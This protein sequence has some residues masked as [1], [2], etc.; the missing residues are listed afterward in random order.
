MDTNDDD[1]APA[2]EREP[3]ILDAMQTLHDIE[4]DDLDCWY[5]LHRTL[6]SAGFAEMRLE[7]DDVDQDD[8]LYELL[9]YAADIEYDLTGDCESVGPLLEKMFPDRMG[10]SPEQDAEASKLGRNRMAEVIHWSRPLP[11][12]PLPYRSFEHDHE[13]E[14]ETNG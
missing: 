5:V 12:R 14:E 4:Q 1:T 9:T 8:E 13:H 7:L 11:A 3:T 6:L 10:D 2:T